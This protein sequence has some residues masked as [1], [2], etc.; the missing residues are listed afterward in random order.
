MMCNQQVCCNDLQMLFMRSVALAGM[1]ISVQKYLKASRLHSSS[2]PPLVD[3]P[4]LMSSALM[5]LCATLAP[6]LDKWLEA[7]STA[8]DRSQGFHERW[9][10]LRSQATESL[11]HLKAFVVTEMYYVRQCPAMRDIHSPALATRLCSNH[12]FQTA[13]DMVLRSCKFGKGHRTSLWSDNLLQWELLWYSTY[14]CH[15]LSEQCVQG[16]PR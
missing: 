7:M 3:K 9:P 16:Q 8:K 4:G 10:Y 15:C 1:C 14:L 11:E 12:N 13:S 2:M 6:A 5:R